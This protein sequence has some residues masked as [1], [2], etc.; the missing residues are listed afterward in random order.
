MKLFDNLY[1]MGFTDIGAWAITT[2]DGIILLDTLNSPQEAE[3][4]M[5][6]GHEEGGA[7]SRRPSSTPSSATGTSTILA[8]RPI[9]RRRAS[10]IALTATDWDL[11]ER[12]PPNQTPQQA[13][14]PRPKRDMILTDGQKITRRRHHGDHP[15]EPGHTEGVDRRDV[16]R[17]GEGTHL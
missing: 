2:S 7:R 13:A 16:P 3:E 4:I 11:I 17:E 1:Y 9:S 10:A 8:A 12:V 5:V 15:R 14:R 6:A